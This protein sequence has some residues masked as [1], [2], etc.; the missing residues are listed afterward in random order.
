[1]E[2]FRGFR[3]RQEFN[4]AASAIVVAGP[5]GTGKTSFFDA[6]QW[7]LLG[8]IERL[9]GLRARRS[10]EHIVNQYRLSNRAVVEVEFLVRGRRFTVRRTGDHRASTLEFTEQGR[11]S[12]FGDDA[13]ALL[14]QALVPGRELTLEMALTTSGLMQQDVMRAV[15]EA[16]PADR[17]RHISTVLGL[18]ALEDFEDAAK[19]VA[20][21]AKSRAEA[22]RDERDSL[23]G[24]LS[25]AHARLAE[26]EQ[27]L[28]TLPQ[29]EALRAETLAALRGAP[30]VL[31]VDAALN[32]GTSTEA[33][34]LVGALGELTDRLESL[35]RRWT[36]SEDTRRSLAP[37]P[38]LEDVQAAESA[39][40]AALAAVGTGSGR[41]ANVEARFASAQAAGED[42]VRLAV[43]AIPML[44]DQCPVCGQAIDPAHIEQ[45]LRARASGT[46]T[47]LALQDELR[48]A[49][50]QLT[51][52]QESA[53]EAENR[54][55]SLSDLRTRWE[56]YRRDVQAVDSLF[57][58]LTSTG[59]PVRVTATSAS[60]LADPTAT[61][62][63][64]LRLSRR[65]VLEF[66]NTLEQGLDRGPVDRAQSEVGSFTDALQL[67][68]RRLEQES[69]RAQQLKALADAAVDARV[70]VTEQRFRAVQPL[71][72]DIFSRLD[73][74]PAFKTIEFELDTY[75]RRGTTSPVV[76][77]LVEGVS[78]DPLVVFSTSQANIAALSYFLAMGWSAG[79]RSLPF[80]LLDDPVQSMDDV[81]VLGFADLCRHLRTGRQLIISTHERRLA[82]LLER[83]L[84]PR[85]AGES[86]AIIEF[87]GWDRS[88]PSVEQRQAEPQVLVDPIRVVQAAS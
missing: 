18:G 83:K 65:R 81:N 2:A 25:E 73:P 42:L 33:R 85:S 43:L 8:S 16:K 54:V 44:T 10:V 14:A 41:L 82:R 4:L 62:L 3:D 34:A 84:T 35:N 38:T 13:A 86:T 49:R 26:A 56:A 52:L 79:E 29:V 88:G 7:C 68:T 21:Q 11:R 48:E 17:Y 53:R 37:E 36:E 74:H 76:R 60:N 64:F 39:R 24:S 59:A 77:D 22:A 15:L 75:Y 50:I 45:E 87:L 57:S 1:M 67:R 6:L 40:D 47:M 20:A 19:D 12:V 58:T 30:P 28:Q 27:R 51:N 63:D 78:A 72:A 69:Q 70:E 5:N 61:V 23:A 32:L 66:L 46:Q 80:V 55:G 31:S 71:V 9:E